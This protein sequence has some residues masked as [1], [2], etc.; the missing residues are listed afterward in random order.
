[1]IDLVIVGGE[2][3]DG[4]GAGRRRADFGIKDGRIV[5]VGKID[6]RAARTID[7]DDQT[8]T[9]GFIDVH[10]HYDAQV[11]WDE[12]VTPSPF[13]GVTTVLARNYGFTLAPMTQEAAPY[14]TSMLARVEG[15]PLVPTGG[16]M[17]MAKMSNLDSGF[18]FDSRPE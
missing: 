6:D 16:A 10:T 13:H 14:L 5:T 4:T 2:V 17:L 12:Y 9:P 3:V 11:A 7:A 15:M 8:V 1:M 18:L